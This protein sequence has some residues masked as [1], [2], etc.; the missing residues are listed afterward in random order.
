LR[1]DLAGAPTFA[2][3]LQRVRTEA[4]GAYAR[5]DLPFERLVEELAPERSLGATPLFQVMV[6]YQNT[7]SAPLA[8]PGL[9]LASIE[10][11]L[12][13]AQTAKFDLAVS[14]TKAP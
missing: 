9:R 5:Q 7:T 3:L 12:G 14:L 6:A 10:D 8:L 4:L 13:E 11:G 2:E 1:I